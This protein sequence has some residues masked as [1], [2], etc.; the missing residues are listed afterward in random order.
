MLV[1]KKKFPLGLSWRILVCSGLIFLT[2]CAGVRFAITPANAIKVE[3]KSEPSS[4]PAAETGQ[5]KT[6]RFY[7]QWWFWGAVMA[8]GFAGAAFAIAP[9]LG[10]TDRLAKG[11]DGRFDAKTFPNR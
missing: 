10:G 9:Q 4:R 3:P 8:A 6:K 5:A 2:S 7:Q 11:L 1:V